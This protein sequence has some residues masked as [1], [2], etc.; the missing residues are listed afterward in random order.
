MH[1][2]ERHALSADM[3]Q[4][5]RRMLPRRPPRLG[6]VLAAVLAA[7]PIARTLAAQP[8]VP[9]AGA[10]SNTRGAAHSPR[11][12]VRVPPPAVVLVGEIA[13]DLYDLS[14]AGS[15]H[16]ADR[17]LVG[18]ED[19]ARKL[20]GDI[21]PQQKKELDAMVAATTEAVRAR[22]R[23]AAMREANEVTRIVAR[24]TSAFEPR[25]PAEVALLDYY[26][27]ALEIGA[28]TSD[29]AL[30]QTT[31]RAMR[32]TWTTVRPQVCARGRLDEADRFDRLLGS[33]DVGPA[34]STRAYARLAA[35]EL[36][37]VDKLERVF[38]R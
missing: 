28:M 24:I 6:V 22:R 37:E 15:W 8:S 33:I 7:W 4:Q 36:N 31:L 20:P 17:R 1:R 5:H 18:M 25:V 13:E 30:L 38:A 26:G 21:E 12:G 11:P 19:A 23:L 10:A 3:P 2:A 16:N 14:K 32:E 9:A 27:R 34:P 35:R 29:M